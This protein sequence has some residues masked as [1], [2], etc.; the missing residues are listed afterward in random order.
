MARLG[1]SWQ[2][3]LHDG[4]ADREP[5]AAQEQVADD[6]DERDQL[7]DAGGGQPLGPPA[8]FGE[9]DHAGLEH[10]EGEAA[11]RRQRDRGQAAEQCCAERRDD[12]LRC[13]PVVSSEPLPTNSR[14][15]MPASTA[16]S[17]QFSPASR[18]GE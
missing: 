7:A 5:V 15:T 17:T 1:S 2:P 13:N 4:A 3:S 16:D 6:D 8:A 11:D 9:L 18:C 14:P 12:E 10:A